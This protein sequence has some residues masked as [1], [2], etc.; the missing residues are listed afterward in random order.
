MSK[1]QMFA[2]LGCNL[3]PWAV[4][5]GLLPLLPAYATQLGAD[6]VWTGYFLAFNQLTLA[7]GCVFSGWLSDRLQRRKALLFVA[8]ILAVPTAWLMGQTTNIWHLAALTATLWFLLGVEATMLS[9]L[10]GLFAEVA[11]RGKVF[12]ILSMTGALGSSIGSTMSGVIADQWGYQSLFAVAAL[13]LTVFLLIGSLLE[14]KVVARDKNG[15]APTTGERRGLGMPFFLLLFVVVIGAIGGYVGLMGRSLA[16]TELGFA[17]AAISIAFALSLAVSL[18]LRPL[19]GWL[20]DRVGR[21]QLMAVSY[22]AGAVGL[23]GLAVSESL[24]QFWLSAAILGISYG[25]ESV[26]SALVTDLLPQESLGLGISMY[27]ATGFAAGILG[28]AGTGHAI[29][30]LGMIPT[31]ILAVFLQIAAIVLLIPIRVPQREGSALE[32]GV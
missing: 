16:M 24:W 22:A 26:G 15:R 6:A 29:L 11:E 20:S 32:N 4:G 27:T 7:V 8:G 21:K 17:A 2:L 1:K 19:F 30:G 9:I 3:I 28:F 23:L 14:D 25:A 5:N 12:G 13:A 10:T 18:P 31:F